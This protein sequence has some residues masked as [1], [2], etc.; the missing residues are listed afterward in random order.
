MGRVR[1]LSRFSIFVADETDFCDTFPQFNLLAFACDRDGCLLGYEFREHE[2][3]FESRI[4][5][6]ADFY[7]A[8]RCD[9]FVAPRD[10]AQAVPLR[11]FEARI[12]FA[13]V[14]ADGLHALLLGGKYGAFAFAEFECF[15]DC[16]HESAFDDDFWRPY[17]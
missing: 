12:D 15:A 16:V 6:G 9:V 8:V 17:L 4:F 3:A 13:C 10:F 5:G 2:G 7:V 1:Y 11:E 14:R